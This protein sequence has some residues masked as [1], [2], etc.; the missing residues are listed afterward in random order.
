MQYLLLCRFNED[1][2]NAIPDAPAPKP[3]IR[4]YPGYSPKTR[5][6]FMLRDLVLRRR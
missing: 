1:D 4:H 5:A 2:W 3:R 6:A